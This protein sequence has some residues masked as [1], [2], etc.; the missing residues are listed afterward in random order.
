[1]PVS[2]G[3]QDQA[4]RWRHG[5]RHY[6]RGEHRKPVG[7]HQRLEEST[8]EARQEEHR[9]DRDDVDQRRVGDRRAHLNRG[10]KHYGEDR[11]AGTLAAILAQ[12]SH[13]VLYVD[14]RVIYHHPYGHDEPSQ[15]HHVDGGAA[16]D[17]L[18]EGVRPEYRRIYLHTGKARSHVVDRFFDA[19]RY[20]QSVGVRELLND[21]QQAG[22]IVDDGITD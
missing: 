4:Q 13:Y 11:F 3:Q 2:S 19:P 10:L 20:L 15:H 22:A 16:R 7:E 17:E 6:H 12:P 5:Q 18:D 9:H 14:D 21:Q 8:R 1:M